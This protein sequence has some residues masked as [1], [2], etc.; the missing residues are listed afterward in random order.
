MYHHIE[1][2]KEVA[3]YSYAAVCSCGLT[4]VSHGDN[5]VRKALR[6][7][8]IGASVTRVNEQ[9]LWCKTCLCGSEDYRCESTEDCPD[10]CPL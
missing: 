8:H 3:P 10:C 7:K 4:A 2:V 6:R 9:E 1:E 5:E